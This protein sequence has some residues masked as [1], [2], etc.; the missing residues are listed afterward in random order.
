MPKEY[1]DHDHRTWE[2]IFRSIPEEW[3]MAPP[4]GAMESCLK[5]LQGKHSRRTLDLGCGIGRWSMFLGRNGVTPVFGAD[6]SLAG[7][8]TAQRWAKRENVKS[9]AFLAADALRLPF[10]DGAFDAVIA[11]LLLDNLDREDAELVMT[12]INRIAGTDASGFFVFNPLLSPEQFAIL[13]TRQNPTQDCMHVVY[14]DKEIEQLMDGWRITQRT[15]SVEGF[16]IVEAVRLA[17]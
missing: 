6:Y 11:A 10:V 14:E 16:R 7:V 9:L 12:E 3:F 5:F 13:K 4:S 15:E 17:T 1:R 8:D 2:K